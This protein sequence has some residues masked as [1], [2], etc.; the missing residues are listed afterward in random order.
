ME[1]VSW[2]KFQIS[3][4]SFFQ[5]NTIG[6]EKLYWVVKDFAKWKEISTILDLYCG[7]GTIGQIIAADNKETEIVWLELLVSAVA[8]AYINSELNGLNNVN[9]IAGKAEKT[10]PEVLEKYKAFDLVV[11]DPPRNGIHPKAL[12]TILELMPKQIIYVSCNP[13]TLSRDLDILVNENNYKLIKI[14]AVDM[15]PH[16]AHIEVVVKLELSN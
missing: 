2:L 15:F 5:T 7:T 12:K 8:D 4:E 1:E 16:T 11:I 9:F 10:L 3:P 6:A 14:Q 13:A